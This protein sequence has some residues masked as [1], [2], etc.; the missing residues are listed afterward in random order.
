VNE[1]LE[2][3]TIG[4][5]RAL[6]QPKNLLFFAE[7]AGL[8]KRLEV[9]RHGQTVVAHRSDVI[10]VQDGATG[11]RCAAHA[12]GVVTLFKIVT[13]SPDLIRLRSL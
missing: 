8:T 12:A 5:R 2:R 9:L 3:A 11:R 4:T 13:R 6:F 7:V 1:N 10:D